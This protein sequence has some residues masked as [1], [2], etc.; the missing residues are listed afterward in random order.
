MFIRGGVLVRVV[1]QGV[2][3]YRVGIWTQIVGGTGSTAGDGDSVEASGY[4]EGRAQDPGHQLVSWVTMDGCSAGV[5]LIF[6]SAVLFLCA[7][8]LRGR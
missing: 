1:V 5:S 6:P 2:R 7:V 3:G 8:L 4:G